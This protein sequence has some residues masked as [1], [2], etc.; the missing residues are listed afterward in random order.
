M[1]TKKQ[2]HPELV[3]AS[4]AKTFSHR[5]PIKGESIT[6]PPEPGLEK[7]KERILHFHLQ[8]FFSVKDLPT[9]TEDVRFLANS[10]SRAAVGC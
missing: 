4:K 9:Y 6:N 3:N 7:I 5:T 1:I 8:V 10:P 2:I